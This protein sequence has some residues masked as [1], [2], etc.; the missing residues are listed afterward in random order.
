VSP[1]TRAPR[2]AY[3]GIDLG[4]SGCRALAID[5]DGAILGE[6]AVSLAAHGSA[7]AID[8]PGNW[9]RA[10]C[11]CLAALGAALSG[12]RPR[13]LA[14]DGTSGTILLCDRTGVPLGPA[15]M[16]NDARAGAEAARI[17][18]MAP[19]D[20]GAH[21][22]S[23]GLAKL[24]WLQVRG[25]TRDA[26]HVLHQSDWVAGMFTGRFGVSDYNNALKLGY[27]PSGLRWPAWLQRLSLPPGLLPE[28]VAPGAALG[29]IQPTL[30]ADLD[31]PS[32]LRVV[33]GTTDGVAAFIAAG[34]EQPGDG[35]T[36]LGSTL[37]IKLLSGKPV[38]SPRHG[39]YSHRLGALWLAGGASNAGGAALLQH[40]TADEMRDLTPRLRP[41]LPT[42]LDYYPLP[43][44]GER[45]PVCDTAKAPRLT[46]VPV[47][48]AHFFQGMLE[49]IARIEADGY[50]L[51]HELGAPS[52]RRVR[53][54]GGGAANQAW[55]RIRANTL[56]V[57]MEPALSQQPAFGAAILAARGL[58]EFRSASP[59]QH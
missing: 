53:T 16:Y 26:A 52:L 55:T 11:D 1:S 5:R 45:F 3:I 19:P 41:D 36:S 38:F 30:A 8:N 15:L 31:L 59:L 14:V 12:A 25:A 39:V 35:V 57:P 29:T 22:A 37:V 43:A 17:A 44:P 46:P 33:A 2:D 50:R 4:T 40:F 27:D 6:S 23:S 28:V 21:G 34:A 13:A 51:L 42:G 58:G 49:G 10:V 32:D 9:W 47:D 24:L 54:S 18:E 56:G 48:R 20:S 7:G